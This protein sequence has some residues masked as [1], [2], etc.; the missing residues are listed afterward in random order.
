M[1]PITRDEYME[2]VRGLKPMESFSDPEGC[3]PFGNM[4]PQMVT[5]WGDGERHI[6]T[7]KKTKENRHQSEWDYEYFKH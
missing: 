2:L 3:S 7:F 4:R 1:T 5:V 6:V